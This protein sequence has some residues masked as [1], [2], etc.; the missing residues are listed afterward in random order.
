MANRENAASNECGAL[1]E[2]WYWQAGTRLP[3]RT[4]STHNRSFDAC[5]LC[6]GQRAVNN[7]YADRC[8]HFAWVKFELRNGRLRDLQAYVL[9]CISRE[10]A[11]LTN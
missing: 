7:E 2:G 5:P 9:T 11:A 10:F 3:Y 1:F 6:Q 8:G 4:R